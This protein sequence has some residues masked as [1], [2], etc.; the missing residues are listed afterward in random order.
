M[1]KV[2]ACMLLITLFVCSVC[3]ATQHSQY[4]GETVI[5]NTPGIANTTYKVSFFEKSTDGKDVSVA[6]PFYTATYTDETGSHYFNYDGIAYVGVNGV[7][8]F[9]TYQGSALTI[10]QI[11]VNN[12]TITYELGTSGGSYT[13]PPI[14]SNT[15]ITI[16]Y[17]VENGGY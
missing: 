2:K 6:G 1:R 12:G 15:T 16:I 3:F 9:Y 17:Q 7:V 13:L 14:T 11:L 8:S 5:V 4:T 10:V